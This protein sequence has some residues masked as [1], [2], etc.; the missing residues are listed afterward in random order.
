MMQALGDHAND[1][2]TRV[3]PGLRLIA[4]KTGYSER[5]AKRII[6]ELL[7]LGAL[8]LVTPATRKR[9]NEYRVNLAAVPAK[10]SLSSDKMSSNSGP[11]EVTSCLDGGTSCPIEGTF[12][13]GSGNICD[14]AIRKEPSGTTKEPKPDHADHGAQLGD[15]I[16]A[17]CSSDAR[18]NGDRIPFAGACCGRR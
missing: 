9:P 4:R 15:G 11:N 10:P 2:G 16:P 6:A 13:T 8:V 3:F 18:D 14:S 12:A 1:D 17:I 5:Q 7:K